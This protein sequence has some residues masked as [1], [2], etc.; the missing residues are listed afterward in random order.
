MIAEQKELLAQFYVENFNKVTA[1]AYSFLHNWDK[2][3]VAAQEAFHIA[4][5]KIDRFLA[6]ES[7]LGWIMRTVENVSHNMIR[8]EQAYLKMFASM[9]DVWPEPTAR[10]SHYTTERLIEICMQTLSERDKT[11][12]H[13]IA[14]D[15]DSYEKAAAD[16]GMTKWQCYKRIERI[17]KKFKD[18]L[19]EL[20]L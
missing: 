6:S 5:E 17:K 18:K 4:L 3:N 1:R 9:E 13:K 19:D 12:F 10:D 15:G 11:L 20:D 8:S 7:K 14:F 2:A 16:L